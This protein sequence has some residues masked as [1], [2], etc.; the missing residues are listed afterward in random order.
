MAA[1]SL[2]RLRPSLVALA[3]LG[4][5]ACS[6]L[7]PHPEPVAPAPVA[8]VPVGPP[9]NDNL[10][11]VLWAQSSVEYRLIAGQTWRAALAMLDRAIKT[12][13]WDAL[14][15]GERSGPVRD[16]PPAVIVDVDETVLDNLAFQ[17]RLVAGDADFDEYAWHQWVDQRAASAVPGALPF[18]REAAARGVAVFY[19]TNRSTDMAPA[20]ADNLRALGFPIASNDQVL[21]LGTVVDGCDADGSNKGCRR[22]LVGRT[23]RVLLQVGDQLGDFVDVADNSPAGREAAVAPYGAWVGERWFVLP[24]PTYGSWEP[25]LFGNDWNLSPTERRARKREALRLGQPAPAPAPATNQ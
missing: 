16:L 3:A 17:A 9:P 8:A 15:H 1:P 10:N 24:N 23:H 22:R 18:L 4:L 5:A 7:A 12:P 21:G 6:T 25:A 14:P 20:T 2:L 13:D 11:A 19:V